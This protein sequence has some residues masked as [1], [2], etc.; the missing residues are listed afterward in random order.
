MF[1]K[2]SIIGHIITLY[3]YTLRPRAV[4]LEKGQL[5]SNPGTMS[6]RCDQDWYAQMLNDTAR[7]LAFAA[8]IDGALKGGGRVPWCEGVFLCG[9]GLPMRYQGNCWNDCW[10]S[11]M[12]LV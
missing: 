12:Y 9:V 2:T 8:G 11:T 6:N 4:S 5:G 3:L 10:A 7:N 1:S